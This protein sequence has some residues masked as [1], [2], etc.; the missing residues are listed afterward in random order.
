MT[1]VDLDKERH[2]RDFINFVEDE[3]KEKTLDGIF[4]GHLPMM[5][6]ENEVKT[7]N[8]IKKVSEHYLSIY[9][10]T[11]L[12]DI[13]ILQNDESKPIHQMLS[14]NQRN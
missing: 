10:T 14:T 12:E 11:L 9:P 6:I 13:E 7:W 8:Y 3:Y 1:P 2:H 5:T 4:K